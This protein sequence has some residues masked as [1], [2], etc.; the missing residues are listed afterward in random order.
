MVDGI[1]VRVLGDSGPFS[2]I[3]KSIGY[4]VTIGQSSYLV[5]CGAPLFQQ[6]GGHKLK[7]INGLIVTHCHDDHKRWFSDY[8]LFNR[9]APDISNKLR[10][11]TSE[12][13]NEELIKASGK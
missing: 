13:I 8:A 5:D 10:L 12:G 3:G 6:L 1:V 7:A 2:R 11:L 4:Q 9:Y